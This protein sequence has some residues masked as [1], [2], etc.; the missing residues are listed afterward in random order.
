MEVVNMRIGE[1]I[2]K[3]RLQAGISQKDF[4]KILKIPVST[5]ANYENNHREPGIEVLKKIAAELNVPITA[6][7]G[8][9]ELDEFTNIQIANRQ[10]IDKII[11]NN[12]FCIKFN[13]DINNISNSIDLDSNISIQSLQSLCHYLN[14]ENEEEAFLYS[15][16]VYKTNNEIFKIIAFY[17]YLK[18]E[19][20]YE[21]FNVNSTYLDVGENLNKKFNLSLSLSFAL[22]SSNLREVAEI[23]SHLNSDAYEKVITSIV[24]LDNSYEFSIDK[25]SYEDKYILFTKVSNAL[26]YELYKLSKEKTNIESNFYLDDFS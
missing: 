6:L 2:K 1:K 19:Y 10:L 11:T 9:S 15:M 4:S 13:I 16:Y 7:V 12:D 14:L 22:G 24:N 8:D 25:L 18:D 20:S 23:I 26:K 3:V 17:Y 5:L 21:L